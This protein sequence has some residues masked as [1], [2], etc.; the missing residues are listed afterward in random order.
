VPTS[1][2][3]YQTLKRISLNGKSL[4]P[5]FYPSPRTSLGTRGPTLIQVYSLLF[6]PILFG[7]SSPSKLVNKQVPLKRIV[8]FCA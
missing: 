7:L 2:L 3:T 1:A 4:I 8:P 6:P 5:R